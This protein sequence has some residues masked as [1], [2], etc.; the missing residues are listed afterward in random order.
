MLAG[1]VGL[2]WR[3]VKL[4]VQLILLPYKILSFIISVV[5][6]GLVLL[7]LA[8]IVVLFVL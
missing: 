1:I 8:V 4:P 3:L 7:L 2:L 6:Y 5:V